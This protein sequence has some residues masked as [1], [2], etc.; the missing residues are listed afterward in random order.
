MRMCVGLQVSVRM[1]H[2]KTPSVKTLH[3]PDLISLEL[4]GLGSLI[5]KIFAF[6]LEQRGGMNR[7]EGDGSFIIAL[8]RK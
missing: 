8:I 3:M 2:R 1:C 7:K 5:K 4:L 6:S